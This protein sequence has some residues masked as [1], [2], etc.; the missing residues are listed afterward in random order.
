[1][2]D[3]ER[4]QCS[5]SITPFYQ[6]YRFFKYSILFK[7]SNRSIFKIEW[8]W[9]TT[10]RVFSSINPTLKF[11]SQPNL[12]E[13]FKPEKSS[14]P[15]TLSNQ[16]YTTGISKKNHW[17]E[18]S[19]E[20]FTSKKTWLPTSSCFIFRQTSI[21]IDIRITIIY[22]RLATFWKTLFLS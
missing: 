17:N 15:P 16:F 11:Q 19:F 9:V 22:R 5:H 20:F 2:I 8:E 21:N 18:Y 4:I 12:K 1:M 7:C 3:R 14:L 13:N 6:C 10:N